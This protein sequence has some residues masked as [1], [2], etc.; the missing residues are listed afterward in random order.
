M[1]H[2][3]IQDYR[4]AGLIIV[5]GT[6][7]IFVISWLLDRSPISKWF[8]ASEGIAVSFITI[9]AFLFGLAISTLASGIWD[10]HSTAHFSLVNESAAIGALISVSK[11]LS[12]QDK[13][14]LN[15]AI[16]NYV[17]GVVDKEWPAMQSG[18]SKNHWLA[19]PELEALSAVANKIATDPN[20][21]SSTGNRLQATIDNLRHARL[22]RLGLAYDGI[23][24]A[25]WPSIYMLSFLLLFSVGLLQLRAPRAMRI[26][27]TMGAL[28]IGSSLVFLY[29]NLS[30]YRGIN[31]VEPTFLKDSVQSMQS[32]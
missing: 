27:L 28:C 22:L 5:F 19:S 1:D 17:N 16:N 26:A 20:Q 29:I 7:A 11:I 12:P 30:P 4:F 6:L 2:L 14:M 25:R 24:F 10:R 18:D 23:D 32:L 13:L 21:L 3:I 31:P 8:K 15:T 9:P